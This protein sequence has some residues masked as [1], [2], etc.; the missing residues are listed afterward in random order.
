[1]TRLFAII[2]RLF[3]WLRRQNS[4][5]LVGFGAAAFLILGFMGLADEVAEG[6]THGIDKAILLALRTPGDTANPIGGRGFE[7]TMIELTS[8]GDTTVLIVI[9]LAV[10]LY[11]LLAGQKLLAGV[12]VAAALG[13]TI[14]SNGLKAFFDRP[15]PDFVAHIVEVSNP[16]FP[17]GHAMMSAVV[18]LT[19]GGML[20]AAHSRKRLKAFCIGLAIA[21]T[22]MVGFTRVYLG[23][24]YP[25][26]VLAGWALG[27][28]WALMCMLLV[29][30]RRS[31]A[32]ANPKADL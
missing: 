25:T 22:L 9:V 16:S 7:H 27:A 31:K 29:Y 11:L 15:R 30:W 19:L 3:G 20:A 4:L 13:G 18:Y 17:S 5:V 6:D 32:V 21:L 10:G 12:A 23:V 24:H 26:D 28:A 8:F 1:M 2:S 14:L